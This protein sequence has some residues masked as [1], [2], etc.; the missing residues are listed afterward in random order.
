M[1]TMLV[2][3]LL[4]FCATSA[5]AAPAYTPAGAVPL[6]DPPSWDYAV[7][8]PA[9]GRVYVAHR[10]KLAVIDGRT[11]RLIG[12]VEGISGGTH[13]TAISRVTGQGFTDDGRNGQVIA[14][15]LTTLAVRAH[16]AANE[17]ADGIA[18]DRGTGHIFVIE[19]DSKKITV[20][21]PKTD[22]ALA[23]IDVGEAMEYPVAAAGE[24]F[25]AGVEK[26]D[27]I[28]VN[29]LTN[30]VSARWPMTDCERPHGLA[31]D[32]GSHRAFVGCSNAKMMVVDTRG[33]QVVTELAI[34]RGNDAVAF[35]SNRRRVFSSNGRDGTVSVYQ[36]VSPDHFRALE[37]IKTQV[38]GRTIDVDPVTGRLFVPVADVDP[39][40]R[41]GQRPKMILG[42]ARVL[43]FDPV[44]R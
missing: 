36:E 16:I 20:V 31:V 41:A 6:G 34:G 1:R 21:D 25:I 39:A 7:V 15:D 30:A 33:G 32:E 18:L 12:N 13:G 10:D 17:D 2:A 35:D 28:E 42:T 9:T 27:L 40:A 38:S 4:G 26:G 8:D 22:T 14:F 11:G 37:D 3:A 5:M 44:E 29:P 24:V 23:N 43:M 19:G